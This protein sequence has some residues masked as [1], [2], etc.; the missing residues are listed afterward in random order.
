MSP[1]GCASAPHR[2]L[3]PGSCHSGTSRVGAAAEDGEDGSGV[4]LQ[5]ERLV[6]PGS[7]EGRDSGV[8]SFWFFVQSRDFLSLPLYCAKPAP[9]E[10]AAVAAPCACHRVDAPSSRPQ[11][12]RP[13]QMPPPRTFS[14]L[15]SVRETGAGQSDPE[16]AC[17]PAEPRPLPLPHL[18]GGFVGSFWRRAKSLIG[19][20]LGVLLCPSA[21]V[22]SALLPYH[23]SHLLHGYTVTIWCLCCR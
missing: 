22:F 2:S 4:G 18:P 15:C 17:G 1:T 21:E 14:G 8:S 10:P 6:R 16:L 3:G 5:L 9:P 23:L 7:R 20:S 11:V 19:S 13:L 12:G